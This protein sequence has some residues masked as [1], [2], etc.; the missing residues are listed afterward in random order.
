[1]KKLE[2]E[3]TYLLKEG[4]QLFTTKA[5]SRTEAEVVAEMFNAVIIKEIKS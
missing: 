1:M 3:K 4:K 2:T 5:R